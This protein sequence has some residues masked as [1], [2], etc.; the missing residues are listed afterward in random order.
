M[1]LSIFKTGFLFIFLSGMMT[2]GNNTGGRQKAAGHQHETATAE[3]A[4]QTAA[5]SLK[6]ANLNKM[7]TAYL[8]LKSALVKGDS[9]AASQAAKAVEEAGKGMDNAPLQQLATKLVSVSSLKEQRDYF[10]ELSTQMISL[11]KQSGLSSGKIYVEYCPMAFDNKGASWL[12]NE[13]AILN[14]YFGDAMLT[15]G[16]VTETIQ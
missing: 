15:C 4:T 5:A 2:C 13:E 14:P 10:G 1:L 3:P 9:L 16:E 11:V 6:D 8:D 12:S 7:Y